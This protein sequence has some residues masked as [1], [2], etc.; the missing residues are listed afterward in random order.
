MLCLRRSGT[1][2]SAMCGS[3]LVRH[4]KGIER[5]AE[6]LTVEYRTAEELHIAP[7]KFGAKE[8]PTPATTGNG[9]EMLCS[10]MAKP[11]FAREQRIRA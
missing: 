10:A 7:K 5:K 4:C 8:Q 6:A 11:R 9:K 3:G 1:A 2:S